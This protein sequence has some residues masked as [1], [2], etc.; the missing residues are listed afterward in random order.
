MEQKAD[1]V[2]LGEYV[3]TRHQ[4]LLSNRKV[5]DTMWQDIA[6]FCLPR[7][8]EIVNKKEYP[9]T[10]RND[11]LFDSTAIYAN[12]VLANGQLSYMSPADSRWFVYEPPAAIKDNDKAKTWFQQCSEIVQLNLANSNF[13]SEVHEL[14]FD[15][16]TFGTYA[17]FCEPG[18]RHPVT[19]TTFPCGSFCISEDDEGL[20]DTIFRE[21]KMTC[22][23]AA[24]K[25]GEENL[26]EKMRKQV[27]EY[28]RTGKGG[29]TL[30]DFVHAIYPRR[31]K[32]RAPGKADGENKPIASVY[33]DKSSKHVVRSSGFDEQ[34]FFAGRHLKWGDSAYGW[35]PGWIAMPEARQLNFLVKQMDAL[36]EIKAFPRILIPSTHE[37]EVDLRSG[38]FTYFDPLNPNALPKEWLTQGEYQIGLEREKRKEAS[39]QRAFHVDLFQMFAMLDQKQMTA[40]EVAERASEK[41]VQFSPTFARKTTELFNPLLRRVFNLHLRQGL[42]PPPPPDVIVQ[43]EMTGIPEIPEPEVTYTS[44]VALAIKSLHNLAFMR[45]MERLAPIIPLKPEILDNYDMDAV[46]RDLGRND[47][48]PADWILDTDKRD[49]MR[50]ERAAQM[51]AMQEQQNMMAQ[52]DMAAKAG[53]IKSDSMVG[54]AIQQSL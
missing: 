34:P 20:V 29:N 54:Q 36:A 39:I 11:V 23:Q 24:D 35:S 41:L 16:G 6:D 51:Q 8:A 27:E 38:G 28:R 37:N 25:F 26:S 17:M 7:K 43:N 31:H 32:D 49:Q 14:Y 3:L 44:R 13:Y 40:R 45:T 42:F 1:L 52:A 47:G 15:D 50:E 10:S 33:V 12:A 21:L 9:D 22:L 4:D 48:V 46:S 19:F 5:W 53:S 18:R 2:R 30:H